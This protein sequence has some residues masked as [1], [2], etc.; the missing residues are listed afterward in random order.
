MRTGVDVG[1]TNTD[2][3]LM[4]GATVVSSIKAPT[5]GDVGAGVV[6][7]IEGVLTQSGVS[8]E[9][10]TGVISAP[11]SSPTPSSSAGAWCRSPSSA[12]RCRRPRASTP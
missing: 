7:A 3:L 4:D 10:I 5:T 6:A 12:S 2:A 8:P 9:T 11:P 1:G